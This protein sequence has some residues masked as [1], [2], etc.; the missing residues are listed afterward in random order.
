[1]KLSNIQILRALAALAVVFFHVGLETAGVCKAV[2]LSCEQNS[3]FGAYGVNLFFMI[4]GFIMVVTSWSSF[5]KPGAT[6]AFLDK[7]LKRIV[8][9]YW[10]VTTIAV[11]GVF[12]VPSMLNVPVLE[13]GYVLASYLFWPVERLNGL[14]RPIANL[15]WT[16]NL[17]MFFYAVFAVTLFFDRLRGLVAAVVFLIGVV[18]LHTTGIFGAQ[19]ALAAVPL[20]FWADPIILNFVL[21]MGVG[22]VYMRGLRTT[23]IDNLL[24][25]AIAIACATVVDLNTEMLRAFPENH[26]LPRFAS[27]LPMLP[28]LLI[29]ALGTQ[30]DL[31]KLWV[32]AGLLLGNASYSLYLIHPFALRPF[33]A[34]WSKYVGDT[35]PVWTFSAVSVLLAFAVGLGCYFVAERPFTNYFARKRMPRENN[36]AVAA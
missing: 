18:I 12:F 28:V 20:N 4:S 33:R 5:G 1:M 32:K 24:L 26:I 23:I 35:M 17:E 9:L 19:G 2:G 6:R 34:I 30:L 15:G 8:P 29:G 27:A 11:V 10:L 16:L 36:T 7:R 22:V 14:V 31:G 21:G 25:L 3:W 13:P